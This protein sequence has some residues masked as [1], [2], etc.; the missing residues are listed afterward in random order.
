MS[1][2]DIPES[3]LPAAPGYNKTS[4]AFID[5]RDRDLSKRANHG[6][7]VCVE[8]GFSG[9]CVHIV[10]TAGICGKFSWLFIPFIGC[11]VQ[12]RRLIFNS[13]LAQFRWAVT[14]TTRSAPPVLMLVDTVGPTCE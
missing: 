5:S 8:A 12:I 10:A 3:I 1:T 6:V 4:V 14:W 13:N 7:Y 2:A 11:A 9:H